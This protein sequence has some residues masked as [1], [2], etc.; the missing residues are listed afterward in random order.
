MPRCKMVHAGV[1]M[2]DADNI[3]IL[4]ILAGIMLAILQMTAGLLTAAV[5][6]LGKFSMHMAIRI[7]CTPLWLAN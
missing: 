6:I 3:M 1:S 4:A 7:H 2:Q 5:V